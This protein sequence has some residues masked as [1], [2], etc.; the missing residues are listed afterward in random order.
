MHRMI[1][2]FAFLRPRFFDPRAFVGGNRDGWQV[3]SQPRQQHFAVPL[4]GITMAMS[5]RKTSN[6]PRA[7]FKAAARTGQSIR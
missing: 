4:L 5:L 1:V 3:A 2:S 7:C 6:S